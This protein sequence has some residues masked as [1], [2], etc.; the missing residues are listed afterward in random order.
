MAGLA[1]AIAGVVIDR[2]DVN[3]TTLDDLTDTVVSTGVDTE[4]WT[5]DLTDGFEERMRVEPIGRL[6]LERIDMTPTGIV[7]GELMHSVSLA[8][9]ETLT[10]IHR[11]WSSRETS[12]ERVVSEEFEQST[13]GGVTENTELASA[14]ETQSR[15]SSELTTEATASASYVFESASVTVGYNS[16]SDDEVTK[17][18]SRKHGISVTRKA[19]SRTRKEH[20]VTFTVKE[21]AGVEDES[22]RTL[23]NPSETDPLRIDFHQMLRQWRVDLYRYGIRLTYDIV[24]PAPGIDLL[25]PRGS[26]CSQAG[27][28]M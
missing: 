22:V 3:T 16:T 2:P 18:D 7:R 10:L 19:A 28:S 27:R 23:T 11:E 13:E 12:F 15:H 6:H 26:C 9:K 4:D 8:P 20:K 24:V 17:S 21:Q 25:A 1:Q 14:T 5:D